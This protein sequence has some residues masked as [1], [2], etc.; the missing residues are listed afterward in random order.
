MRAPEFWEGSDYTSRL[1]AA[2]L[3]PIGYLYGASVA[4]KRN[5]A[6]PFRP[7][8]KVICVGN[9]SAGGTGKT[10]VAIAIAAM[11][12]RRGLKPMFLTRGYGGREN[13]PIFVNLAH[14]SAKQVGDE[15]LLLAR[16][17]PTIVARDRADG[18]RLADEA[19]ADFI[20]MDDGHQN[21]S[22][23]KDLSLVVVDAATGF[24]NRHVLPAGPLR[25]PVSQGLARADAV[26]L[27]GEGNPDLGAF[28]GTVARAR[29]NPPSGMSFRGRRVVAFAGTGR[30]E[31][32]F[33][34]MKSLGA[35]LIEASAFED[36]HEYTAS[37]LARLKAKA[38]GAEA[39]LV[40]TEKDFVRLAPAEREGVTTLPITTAFE[41]TSAIEGLLDR[42]SPAMARP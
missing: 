26:V 4:W 30:P 10:P 14:D 24:G 7:R 21:F 29:F 19:Q 37:E 5:N 8:A 28:T 31:K 22:L 13:G 12:A 41:D 27:T 33:G 3:S 36:H 42:V 1:A 16:A 11:I 32:F 35:E 34:T 39:L 9:L 18:A 15:P 25:E 40:T 17:A 38:R 23:A 2:L 20:V 6:Q